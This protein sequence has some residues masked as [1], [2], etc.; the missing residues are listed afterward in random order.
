MNSQ[1][2]TET[3]LTT[4]PTASP[5]PDPTPNPTP[6][7]PET[8]PPPKTPADEYAS[9]TQV[10]PKVLCALGWLVVKM[11]AAQTKAVA[12]GQPLS[13]CVTEETVREFERSGKIV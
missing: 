12:T 1:T 4:L 5:A 3:Q 8:P 9:Q 2:D 13:K 6:T 10:E 7:A 11:K